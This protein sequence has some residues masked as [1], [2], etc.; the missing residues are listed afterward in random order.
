MVLDLNMPI[1]DGYETCCNIRNL[2]IR[3]NLFKKDESI[4][5]FLV[6]EVPL[7]HYLPV[8]VALSS[9]INTRIK[10]KTK[11]AGFVLSLQSPLHAKTIEKEIEPLLT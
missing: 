11:E 6:D 1:S 4:D 8:I 9:L 2:F 10:D 5:C 3:E 7:I